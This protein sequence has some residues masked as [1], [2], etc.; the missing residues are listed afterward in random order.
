MLTIDVYDNKRRKHMTLI[1]PLA[2]N[3]DHL[4]SILIATSTTEMASG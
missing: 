1:I 2:I 3:T 4:A